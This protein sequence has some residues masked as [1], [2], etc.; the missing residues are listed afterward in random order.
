MYY[1]YHHYPEDKTAFKSVKQLAQ[2]LK[3][4]EVTCTVSSPGNII[5][6]TNSIIFYKLLLSPVQ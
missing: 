3:L 6:V 5:P 4:R 2:G 1:Y